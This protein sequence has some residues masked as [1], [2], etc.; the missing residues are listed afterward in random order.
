MEQRLRH[1]EIGVV[2]LRILAHQRDGHMALLR[3]V[4]LRHQLPPVPHI[5]LAGAQSQLAAY[6]PAQTFFFQQ[7]GYLIQGGRRQV[8]DNAV[9][10]DVA[11]QC[12]LLPHILGQRTIGAAHQDI[13]LD[14]H[15][16][17]LLH[18]VLGGLALQLAAAGNGHHQRHVDIQHVLPSLLRRHLADGL[19]VRL[20]LDV[21]YRAADLRDDHIRL[22]VIHGV[23]PPLDLVGHMGDDLHRAA[24][25]AALPFPV[26]YRPE[27]LAGGNGAVAGQRL[28]HEA[29]IVPQVQVR[30]RP[31][32][33]DEH[34]AVLIGA[35]GPRIYIQVRIELLVSHPQTAL[36]Q[37]P[38][39]RCR[40]DALSQ[41]GHHAAGHK[42]ILHPAI[43]PVK[44]MFRWY[45][46]ALPAVNGEKR[47]Y[48]QP[49]FA[50]NGLFDRNLCETETFSCI[51]APMVVW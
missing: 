47:R 15:A 3:R 42:N 40:A 23:Q 50:D 6:H 7:Q 12:D 17:Q 41:P 37:Q 28:V 33:G 22:S 32:V 31:I 10:A 38:A 20:A 43:S 16:Q 27:D 19:Q 11:E 5:R 49:F 21:A 24:Q 46:S 4:Y 30:F 14:A 51:A 35:H 36:L 9:L 45:T 25:I 26:Q 2:Q 34:L 44:N 18:R 48:F 1:A 13:R 39:Q 8:G 29:L